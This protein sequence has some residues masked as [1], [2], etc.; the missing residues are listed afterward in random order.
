MDAVART[1]PKL[2]VGRLISFHPRLGKDEG[3]GA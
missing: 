2:F 3:H 1:G